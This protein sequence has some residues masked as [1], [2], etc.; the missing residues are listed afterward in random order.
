MFHHHHHHHYHIAVINLTYPHAVL[1]IICIFLSLEFKAV[2]HTSQ[3]I[4]FLATKQ[5]FFVAALSIVLR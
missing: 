2:E 1:K 3:F 4:P 5:K